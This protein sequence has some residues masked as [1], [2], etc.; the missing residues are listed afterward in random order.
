MSELSNL[1]ER[2]KS[3]RLENDLTQEEL[4]NRSELSKGFISQLEN[5]LTLPSIGTLEDILEVLGSS[6]SEFFGESPVDEKIVFT[7][8]DFFEKE[9][10]ELKHKIEWLVPNAL[11]YEMEPI[12]ITLA[13]GGKSDQD[14][15]HAGEEF[16]YVLE[17]EITLKLNNKKYKVKKGES[18]YY[19]SHVQ[20]Q[21][22]NNTNKKALVIWIS[23]PPMF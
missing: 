7:K 18:F 11:K 22:E 5:N 3:L 14:D 9:D 20:H 2:I 16:G 6:L 12:L 21:I 23:T 17:G 1:G 15:P 8:N 10:Q 13:P 19:Q 4:A